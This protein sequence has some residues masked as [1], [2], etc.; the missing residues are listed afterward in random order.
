MNRQ[1]LLQQL[2]VISPLWTIKIGRKIRDHTSMKRTCLIKGTKLDLQLHQNCVIGEA[3]DFNE[4]LRT[5]LS[6]LGH[7]IY[8]HYHCSECDNYSLKLDRRHPDKAF[9]IH[10]HGFIEHFKDKHAKRYIKKLEKA[11]KEKENAKS[12]LL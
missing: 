2:R 4:L 1:I 6:R 3:F 11:I 5:T 7:I 10:L 8:D 12:L 9:W